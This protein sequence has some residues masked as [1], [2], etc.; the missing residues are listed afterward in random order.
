MEFAVIHENFTNVMLY[1]S[2]MQIIWQLYTY[3]TDKIPNLHYALLC[4]P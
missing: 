3:T 2:Y 4:A 1:T